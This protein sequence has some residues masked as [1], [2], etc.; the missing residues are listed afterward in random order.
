MLRAKIKVTIGTRITCTNVNYTKI[1]EER[2]GVTY[3]KHTSNKA[4]PDAPHTEYPSLRPPGPDYKP[5]ARYL[6]FGK[7]IK[8]PGVKPSPPS[9]K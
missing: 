9:T 6:K 4:A 8:K 2:T 5:E 3:C 1:V 7:Q